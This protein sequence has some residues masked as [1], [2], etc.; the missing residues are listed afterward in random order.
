[1]SFRGALLDRLRG[2]DARRRYPLYLESQRDAPAA[3]RRAQGESLR[4]LLMA[5]AD[6]PYYTPLIE[7]ARKRAGDDPWACLAELPVLTRS[8]VRAAGDR[9]F[10]SEAQGRGKA[11]AKA[12]GGSTGEPLR[13]AL[14][15]AAQSAQW[16]HLWRAWQVGGYRP[17]DPLGVVAGRSLLA[18]DGVR[19]IIY[20]RLQNWTTLD[21]FSLDEASMDRFA[22]ALDRHHVRYLYGYAS[23]LELFARWLATQA[24]R[25]V[26]SAVFTTAEELLP[27]A[28]AAIEAGTRAPVFDTYGANDGGISAFE[29]EAHD[30][31]HVGEERALVEVL[32]DDDSAAA[33]GEVGRVVSTDLLNDVFPFLRYEVGDLGALDPTP[34]RCGRTL[35]RLMR[36]SGRLSDVLLLPDG[37]RVHGELFSHLLR[38]RTEVRRFQAIQTAPHAIEVRIALTESTREEAKRPL[39]DTLRAELTAL[40]PGVRIEL[41]VTEEFTR[42]AAGKVPLVMARAAREESRSPLSG[43]APHAPGW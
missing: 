5:A 10:T 43:D 6:A 8:T 36:L 13:Y 33:P 28:R 39:L 21:A 3:R 37:R 31:M 41:R 9:M 26:L 27:A 16:A 30:G 2:L 24:T 12:T 14:S 20:A 25:P 40:L 7:K 35:V 23:A 4:S 19:R 18:G 1:M 42:T 17:G 22:H 29:C 32:R 34:C 15:P 38:R 11:R